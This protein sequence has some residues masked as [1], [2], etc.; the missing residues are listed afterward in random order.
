M[1]FFMQDGVP[2]LAGTGG[3]APLSK[4]R[5]KAALER[6]GWSYGVDGDGDIGGDW[7]L[8]TFFF[9]ATGESDELLCIRGTWRGELEL[10]DF[11]RAVELCNTW[12][13]EQIWPKAYTRFDDDGALHILTEHNVDY[14]QGITDGQLTQQ[15]VCA[16]ST[17]IA[18]F[19]QVNEI[20]P[21]VWQRFRPE[22]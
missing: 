2:V 10:A 19:E 15:L 5:I 16:V 20:F 7:E 4:D 11:T 8:A 21:E 14:E 18:F 17:S 1:E 22:E 12:N 3:L 9:F 6:E 13:A